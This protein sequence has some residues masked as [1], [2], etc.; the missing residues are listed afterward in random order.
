[1]AFD[2][3]KFGDSGR[4]CE[5]IN[6]PDLGDALGDAGVGQCG[7]GHFIPLCFGLI[8]HWLL[9]T[10]ERIRGRRALDYLPAHRSQ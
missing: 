10:L 5:A 9:Q 6:A 1:M 3:T 4:P 8:K 7:G 2:L